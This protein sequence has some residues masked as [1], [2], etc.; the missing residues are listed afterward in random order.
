MSVAFNASETAQMKLSQYLLRRSTNKMKISDRLLGE[1][2][3]LG[4]LTSFL[5]TLG[6]KQIPGY[7]NGREKGQRK[8]L[9][10]PGIQLWLLP[11]CKQ[12]LRP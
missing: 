9:P 8:S 3:L 11:D 6:S 10:S 2:N 5:D 4:Y 1:Q 12:L 7:W